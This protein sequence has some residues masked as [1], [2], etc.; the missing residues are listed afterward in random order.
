MGEVDEPH[1]AERQR[2]P[3]REQRVEAAEQHALH[4]GVDPVHRAHSR[5]RR[6]VIAS[7]LRSP[8]RP[9][10]RRPDPRACSTPGRRSS[11]ASVMSCSTITTVVP[12]AVI[13]GQRGV[14]TSRT[15]TGAR[16]ER[17]LV[18]QD[19]LAGCSSA[20]ARSPRPAAR[21]PTARRRG[22][23]SRRSSNGNTSSTRGRPSTPGP[24]A[25]GA[26]R[27]GSPRPSGSGTAAVPRARGRCRRPPDRGSAR[28]R[29]RR[30]AKRID[31]SADLH[32]TH[33]GPQ[34]RR[35]CRRRW[36]R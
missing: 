29:G 35:S 12:P 32:L 33:H 14:Q 20:P 28:R 25:V 34:Q 19:Q 13:D 10:E 26:D 7:W 11:S 36:R 5:S 4:D 2:Q 22:R 9:L 18:E 6:S 30:P 8:G 15:T 23:P 24:P 1:H 31:P 27:A 16:P 17:H 21:R 3:G